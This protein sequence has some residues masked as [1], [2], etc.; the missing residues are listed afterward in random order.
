VAVPLRRA[1]LRPWSD[2]PSPFYWS[3]LGQRGAGV[4]AASLPRA[5]RLI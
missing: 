2:P 1:T 4:A 3:T 5:A